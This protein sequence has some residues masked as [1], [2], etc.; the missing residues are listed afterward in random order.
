MLTFIVGIVNAVEFFNFQHQGVSHLTGRT[1]L[2]D[3]ALAGHNAGSL[4]HLPGITVFFFDG[5]CF[6]WIRDSG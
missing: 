6:E 1:T 2:V 5:G 4:M 3:M